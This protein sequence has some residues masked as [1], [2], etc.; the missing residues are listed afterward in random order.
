MKP[1]DLI[2]VTK[3]YAGMWGEVV[4]DLGA[5]VMVRRGWLGYVGKRGVVGI[6]VE[7]KA[8][9]TL[10][11]GHTEPAYHGVILPQWGRV[12]IKADFVKVV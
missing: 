6:Y 2:E 4:P 12:W 7:S 8:G 10:G 9:S 11:F 5:E 1:G 3:D